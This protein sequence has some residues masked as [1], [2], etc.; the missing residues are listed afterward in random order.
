MGRRPFYSSVDCFDFSVTLDRVCASFPLLLE[1]RRGGEKREGNRIV[2]N[3]S[4]RMGIGVMSHP[5][6]FSE[7]IL[8]KY[9]VIWRPFFFFYFLFSF[10]EF[11]IGELFRA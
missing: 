4:N 1:T 11:V 6:G 10:H 3:A 8:N 9:L 2:P 5:D 7:N